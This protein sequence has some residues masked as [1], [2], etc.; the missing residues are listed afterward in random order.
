MSCSWSFKVLISLIVSISDANLF[1]SNPNREKKLS[2]R[3]PSND[4][5]FFSILWRAVSIFMA[6]SFC[7]AFF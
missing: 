6:S 2:G 1:R 7:L 4:G 3:A 5:L